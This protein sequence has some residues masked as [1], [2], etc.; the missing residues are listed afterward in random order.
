MLV[1]FVNW[2]CE[3][4]GIDEWVDRKF[5][6]S[7]LGEMPDFSD[8]DLSEMDEAIG[9]VV[10]KAGMQPVDGL[11][12]YEIEADMVTIR[13]NDEIQVVMDV[14]TFNSFRSK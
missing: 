6:A 1:K 7:Q 3:R 11:A 9:L 12:T 14:D 4:T 13:V 2:L 10:R 5:A 8:D